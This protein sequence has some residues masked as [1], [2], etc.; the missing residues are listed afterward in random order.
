MRKTVA[1][2]ST[3]LVVVKAISFLLTHEIWENFPT[4]T[5]SSALTTS[6]NFVVELILS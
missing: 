6:S 3:T 2:T 5:C 4:Q 1:F